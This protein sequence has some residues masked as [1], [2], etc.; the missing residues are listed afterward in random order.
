M[1][2]NVFSLILILMLETFPGH[3]HLF[4]RSQG[5]FS[6]LWYILRFD[7]FV[8]KNIRH[9]ICHTSYNYKKSGRKCIEHLKSDS[10]YLLWKCNS[11][12]IKKIHKVDAVAASIPF[13]QINDQIEYYL[14]MV[15]NQIKQKIENIDQVDASSEGRDPRTTRIELKIDL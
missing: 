8:K 14:A 10:N 11:R 3:V 4:S 7:I 5:E 13:D 6:T 15:D 9:I 12:L 2:V 1:M